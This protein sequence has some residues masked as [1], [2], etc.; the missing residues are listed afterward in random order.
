M[1]LTEILQQDLPQYEVVHPTRVDAR[2]HFLSNFLSHHASRVQRRDASEGPA[3]VDQV[4]YQLWHGGHR[5]HF[6]LTLNPHLLAPGFL[7]ER[8]YGGLE[9]AKIHPP[10]SSQCHFLGDVWDETVGKGS[11]AISTCDGL[12]SNFKSFESI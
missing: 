10:G 12:V 2:G 3:G 6:N 9:G 8:R 7:T 1:A 5:L 11:A 4:F